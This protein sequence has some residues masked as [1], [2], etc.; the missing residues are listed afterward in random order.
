MPGAQAHRALDPQQRLP[1]AAVA[2]R[3]RRR[4]GAVQPGGVGAAAAAGRPRPRAAR[5]SFSAL[6]ATQSRNR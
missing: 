3:A 5:R 2:P 6:R 1:V 4:G